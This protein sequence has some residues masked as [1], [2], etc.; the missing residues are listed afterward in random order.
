MLEHHAFSS[1][2]VMVWVGLN[3]VQ[4]VNVRCLL[5]IN[6]KEHLY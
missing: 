6:N 5:Q 3:G 4:I 2:M 1:E